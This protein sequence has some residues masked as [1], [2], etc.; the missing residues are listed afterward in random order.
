MCG[1]K[2][3]GLI[4]PPF[5]GAENRT[6]GNILSADVESLSYKRTPAEILRILYTTSN[7]HIPGGF[8]PLGGN[9]RIARDFLT[10]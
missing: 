7:E 10:E 6:T 5:L 4:V 1:L 9:G 3:E 2:D 8:F